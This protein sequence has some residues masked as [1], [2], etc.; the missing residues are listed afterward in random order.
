MRHNPDYDLTDADA[1]RQLIAANPWA[2]LVSPTGEGPIASHVPTILEPR[3]DGRISVLSHLGRPDDERHGLG[4]RDA[5]MIFQGPHGYVSPSW[6]RVA[7]AV[8][9]WNFSVVHLSGRP[10]LLS[11]DEN[12]A[13]LSDTVDA[14]EQ[15]NDPAFSLG[16]V[17]EYAH[18]IVHGTVGFRFVADGVEAK[19]KHSQDKPAEVIERVIFALQVR[20]A[21]ELAEDMARTHARR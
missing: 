10:E 11:A 20:G 16:Q 4:T 7:P 15:G 18:R 3:A 17:G 12:Y 1:Q 5:L 14:Y 6:Y 19:R 2:I 9:T 21:R 13:V 8:P